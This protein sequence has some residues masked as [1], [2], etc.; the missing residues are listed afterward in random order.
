M[1]AENKTLFV[2][3]SAFDVC[4]VMYLNLMFLLRTRQCLLKNFTDHRAILKSC[5]FIY[6]VILTRSEFYIFYIYEENT[7]VYLAGLEL[8]LLKHLNR[9]VDYIILSSR[10]NKLP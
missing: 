1:S 5:F 3:L 4:A 9:E 6:F 10:L 2:I 7:L 8:R